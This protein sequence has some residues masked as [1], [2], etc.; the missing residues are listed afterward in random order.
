MKII[1][2]NIDQ[3][4][5]ALDKDLSQNFQLAQ[6]LLLPVPVFTAASVQEMR[7][8]VIKKFSES[9]DQSLMKFK[10][11]IYSNVQDNCF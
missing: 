8:A 6:V 10:Q 9:A 4:I 11:L 2:K 3:E 1:K 5:K 7:L